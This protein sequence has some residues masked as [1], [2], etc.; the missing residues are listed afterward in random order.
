MVITAIS[1]PSPSVFAIGRLLI[2]SLACADTNHF[3]I[4]VRFQADANP[5]ED[6]VMGI[7]RREPRIDFQGG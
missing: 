2:I 3:F 5:N 6:I 1:V 4:P 7:L